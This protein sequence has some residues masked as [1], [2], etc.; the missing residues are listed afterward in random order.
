[1]DPQQRLL[2]ECS[3]R[4]LEDAGIAVDKL[5]STRTGVFIGISNN[6]YSRLSGFKD[7][8]GYSL[9][10]N[11]GSIAAGRIS[12]TY[13]FKGPCLAVD[14]ACSSSLVAVHLACKSLLE[15]ESSLALAGG[16]N[17]ILSSESMNR[18]AKIG[19]LSPDGRCMP[20]DA[21]ANGIVR[22]EGVGIV[23]LKPLALALSEGD[24]I[25][26]II[27]GSAVS[28]DGKSSGLTAPSRTAQEQVLRDACSGS[29]ISPGLISYV[30]AHG[31][32][33]ELGDPIE[34]EALENVLSEGRSNGDTCR[35][36]SVKS[37]IGHTEAAAGIAGLIKTSLMLLK[38]KLVPSI[39]FERPNPHIPFRKTC[40]H[41]QN[42]YSPFPNDVAEKTIYAGV[43]SFGIS[44]SNA[45]AIL[46][47]SPTNSVVKTSDNDMIEAK[48]AIQDNI[49]E[50]R[51]QEDEHA[52]L[53]VLSANDNVALEAMVEKW[54]SYISDSDRVS[55]DK[56]PGI[57][58][59]AALKRTVH[60]NRISFV[61]RSVEELKNQMHSFL[62]REPHSGVFF[63]S[64]SA[65][66][67]LPVFV[68]SGQGTQYP[69]M[70]SVLLETEPIFRDTL[71][72]CDEMIRKHMGRSI[73][74][75]MTA[76]E[77]RTLLNR[78]DVTQPAIFVLQVG[79]VKVLESYG[80]K[81]S[82]VIGHSMGEVAA[83][84]CAGVMDLEQ[85]IEIIYQRGRIMQ[86]ACGQGAMAAIELP[87]AEVRKLIR[88]EEQS[89][90][91]AVINSPNSTVVSGE[92]ATVESLITRL[93]KKGVFTR[94][95]MVHGIAG[96]GPM[97]A[98][99]GARLR[100]VLSNLQVHSPGVP[101]Y[102]TVTGGRI[103]NNKQNASYWQKNMCDPVMFYQAMDSLITEIDRRFV[104]IEFSPHP[105]LSG[106]VS[107]MLNKQKVDSVSLGTLNSNENDCFSLKELLGNLFSRG[108]DI[109]FRHQDKRFKYVEL[110]TYPFQ[111]KRYW[112][113]DTY[114]NRNLQ[115]VSVKSIMSAAN[116]Q[117]EMIPIDLDPYSFPKKLEL[118]SELTSY[119]IVKMLK[120]S[121]C[122][123]VTE[124]RLTAIEVL[125]KIEAPHTFS[126]VLSRWLDHLVSNNILCCEGEYFISMNP[127]PNLP[128]CELMEQARN[129]FSDSVILLEYVTN[130][131]E[132]L[133]EILSGRM[134]S[135]ETLFPG[136]SFD[137]ADFLYRDWSVARYFNAIVTEAVKRT[138][139]SL[140]ANR[141]L[142]ILE[143]GAGTGGT[144]AFILPALPSE[145]IAYTFY[146]CLR[147][148]LQCS[149]EEILRF[150]IR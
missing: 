105:S 16:V 46:E 146:R 111:G 23:A 2:L 150:S 63:G 142:R 123:T 121:G 126:S 74:E 130:C 97:V 68:F 64:R 90:S 95:L 148:F 72:I 96:H 50:S 73:I 60:D 32:G 65:S 116:K 147:I 120:K 117:S 124:E 110:P 137:T 88:S 61:F 76:S 56:L 38:R 145:R 1:M 54:V 94:R 119:Y 12:Y 29:G 82:A 66:D 127:L 7:I 133:N 75:E 62:K 98:P 92:A 135:L 8:D 19:A 15:G 115:T 122:F 48:P 104:C 43:S 34:A 83:S 108:F 13:G 100:N 11:A 57:C 51:A 25:Y 101:L 49:P 106:A 5:N 44:G 22:S 143:I 99:H 47:S 144:A 36:G 136:G 103:L 28:H 67:E 118:L 109:N 30:E 70:G 18:I 89:I 9:T 132:M 131:G 112:L 80:I 31:T 27:R 35:I 45:H 20:F 107:G 91:I 37:N 42:E 4:A 85:A 128:S 114:V 84:W 141:T 53:L 52:H 78:T 17:L 55:N 79:L 129:A 87:C 10:G 139:L 33:T 77:S 40:L 3:Y 6:D 113:E 26:S 93:E 58:A 86:N 81:P 149:N 24:N 71:T 134:N 21:R 69:G 125:T 41:V 102:S 59:S 14:T 138:A 140:P 39:H